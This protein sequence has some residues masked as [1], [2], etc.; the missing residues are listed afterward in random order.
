MSDAESNK[1]TNKKGEKKEMTLAHRHK[2]MPTYYPL[3][4]TYVVDLEPGSYMPRDLMNFSVKTFWLREDDDLSLRHEDARKSFTRTFLQSR[5]KFD[6]EF[7]GDKTLNV[8]IRDVNNLRAHIDNF[9]FFGQLRDHVDV[10]LGMDVVAPTEDGSVKEGWNGYT[11]LRGDQCHLKI[12]IAS[13]NQIFPLITIA[14]TLVHEMA[15]AYLM[16][17]SAR[18]CEKCDKARL[19][20][21]G[22][23]GDGHGLVFQ[24]LHR[25]MVTTIREW[26]DGL[27]DLAAKDCPG[28]QVSQSARALAR[29]AYKALPS[30]EKEAY[31]KP[32]SLL[33]AQRHLIRITDDEEVL[34]DLTLRDR[35]LRAE[36]DI[37]VRKSRAKGNDRK[38]MELQRL[39]K[40]TKRTAEEQR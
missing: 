16:L 4:N 35:A 18:N 29:Q 19:S 15:H 32:R 34:V 27:K 1:S 23:P 26:D 25:I 38:Q 24:M 11:V 31:R 33:Q 22:L 30:A 12:N 36:E 13:K 14:E 40:A 9:F 6:Q 39:E 21:I 2:S 37:R 7:E 10:D 8:H 5:A 3:D 17:F 28:L 20:T